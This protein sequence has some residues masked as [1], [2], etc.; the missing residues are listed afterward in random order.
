L[1][2]QIGFKIKEGKILKIFYTDSFAIALPK[3]HRFPISK[4]ALLRKRLIDSSLVKPQDLYI[5][6]AATAAEITRVHDPDYLRR[7]QNGELTAR[8]VRRIG[9]PWSPGLVER[10]RRSAGATVET[11]FAALEDR[12]AVHLGGGTHHAFSEQGQGYCIF[13]DGAI[14]ARALQAE[15]HIQRVLILDCDVHQGNG[16]AAILRNDPSVF[17]FSIHG[18]NNFPYHKEKSDLDIA[19]DDGAGDPIYLDAL[20]KGLTESLRRAKAELVIYLAGADP[21][22]DDRF[23]RLALSKEGL[24]ERDSMV[25]QYCHEA[26]LQV[27]VTMAGGYAPNIEDT[28]D[29]HFKT[30]RIAADFQESYN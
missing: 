4:Y 18:K 20:Q 8:E 23:G 1:C 9:L 10:A 26:G 13:N 30:V 7:V 27:A 21:Y 28:V 29:I 19:L 15:T 22:A 17:T 5:P 12:V 2:N 16:T 24:A 3:D 11:C 14:A 25:F 6:R